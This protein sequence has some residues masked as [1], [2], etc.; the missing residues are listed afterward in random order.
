M[1]KNNLIK[2]NKSNNFYEV[3]EIVN[4]SEARRDVVNVG[5]STADGEESELSEYD[6]QLEP[7]E[8]AKVSESQSREENLRRHTRSMGDP[9]PFRGNV[10]HGTQ[11]R[12]EMQ[13]I[14][15]SWN[16]TLE[17]IVEF[18]FVGGTDDL[19]ENPRTFQEAWNHADL[20]ER[21]KW[22]EAIRKE[23]HDMVNS[24]KVW[25]N[26]KRNEIPQNRRV[27]GCKWVF[28]K[29][30]NGIYRAR[31]CAI[32]YSQI[33]GIDHEYAFAPVV[34]ETTYR[35]ML[36]VGLHYRWVMEIVD[37]ET[38]FLYGN[39]EEEIYMKIPEG[40]E[41]FTGEK[42]DV[43]DAVILVQAVYGLVQAARQFFKKLRDTLVHDM[44]FKKC[45]SDQCLLFRQS[46]SGTVIVCLYIDD[47]LVIGNDAAVQSFKKELKLYFNTKEEGEMT[48]YVGCMVRR[49]EDSIYLHQS[50]LIKKIERKF[51]DRALKLRRYTTPGT[52]GVGI[53]RT[54]EEE[55]CLNK[56]EQTEFRSAVGMLLFLTKFSRP[57][58]AN[59]VRELSKVNNCANPAHIKEML[60]TIKF[61][62]DTRNWMLRYRLNGPETKKIKWV[63]K[64]YCDSDFAGD[65][66]NRLSVLGYGIYLFGCLISW[67]SR[68]MRT[69]ALSSTEAEYIAVSEICCELL[70]VRQILEF[71]G[72]EVDCPIVIHCDNIGAIFLA[73][74][75]KV[76]SRTK[77][78]D[79]KTHFVREYIDKGIVKIIFI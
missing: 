3:D 33:A 61:V 21:A 49:T 70:F 79:L 20:K 56:E 19:Y 6:T 18:A 9:R 38:A 31:L 66:D 4:K 44:G 69:H 52:P 28:K 23:F 11:L 53:I 45:L 76:S 29:K 77:H 34:S 51:G 13:K 35:I 26:V 36:V 30:K 58:I 55:S 42:Y 48:E 24:R 5:D 16:T 59:A 12:R 17:D 10:E 57:D 14:N 73:N 32:G 65:K 74:N 22:R 47:T 67:K 8:E 25:R 7:V 64:A 60:R 43:E 15:D 39:L 46:D 68:A 78:I 71:L 41:Y 27:I 37:V 75:A 2:E 62:L 40:L 54:S 50:D 72:F 1:K 63:F